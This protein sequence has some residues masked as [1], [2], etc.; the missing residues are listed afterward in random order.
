MSLGNATL[1]NPLSVA[2]R[3]RGNGP[4]G[5]QVDVG[6]F[7]VVRVDDLAVLGANAAGQTEAEA[8]ALRDALVRGDPSLAGTLQVMTS[9]ELFIEAA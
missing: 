9:H 4:A 1:R 2:S 6:D 5:V 7:R 3:K 8:F